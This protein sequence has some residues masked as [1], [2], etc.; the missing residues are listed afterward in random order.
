V[1]GSGQAPLQT[2]PKV[3]A[4][5]V[6]YNRIDFGQAIEAAV[7][8]NDVQVSVKVLISKHTARTGN[9]QRRNAIGCPFAWHFLLNI[10]LRSIPLI[11]I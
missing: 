4:H 11:M 2:H 8:G 6:F 7:R 9:F 5:H 1:P 10:L 3:P